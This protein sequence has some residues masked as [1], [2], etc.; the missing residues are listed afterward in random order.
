MDTAAWQL[1]YFSPRRLAVN[2][3]ATRVGQPGIASDYE[4]L[5]LIDT[6]PEGKTATEPHSGVR[7]IRRNR[8][9][10]VLPYFEK[11]SSRGGMIFA[12]TAM[13]RSTQTN[14]VG[15]CQHSYRILRT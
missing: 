6:L 9:K 10:E 12:P 7:S 5:A 14:E 4:L 1:K 11:T 15:R 8:T 2:Q 3:A 13:L